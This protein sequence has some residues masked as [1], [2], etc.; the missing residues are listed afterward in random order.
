MTLDAFFRAVPKE[1]RPKFDPLL[2]VLREQLS[3]AKV[4]MVGDEAEKL[5]YVVGKTEDGQ[6]AGVKTTLLET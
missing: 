3:G 4:F 1:D 5:T 6:L 2:K